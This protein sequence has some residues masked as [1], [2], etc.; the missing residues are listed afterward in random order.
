MRSLLFSVLVALVALAAPL[1]QTPQ[2]PDALA[3]AIQEKFNRIR[4]FKAD[5]RQ[6]TSGGSLGKVLRSEGTVTVKKP[7]RMRW[8]YSKPQK[9]EIISDGVTFWWYFPDDNEAQRSDVPRDD[10]ATTSMQFLAGKG[11]ITRDFVAA[12]ATSRIPGTIAL[13]L[14][15]RQSDSEFEHLVLALDPA[16]LQ[17]RALTTRDHQGG[18]NT[19]E[20]FKLK[21]NTNVSD[22]EFKFTPPRGVV[23]TGAGI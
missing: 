21:E 9:Q 2:A 3:R 14:T 23:V 6:T 10:E 13:R 20:F 22:R 15:P 4:D 8:V 11:D 5:F 18:D 12:T 19:I 17:I 1:A 7:G 16:T